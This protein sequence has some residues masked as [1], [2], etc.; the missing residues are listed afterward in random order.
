MEYYITQGRVKHPTG[1]VGFYDA[2]HAYVLSDSMWFSRLGY[3]IRRGPGHW[4][5]LLV[6]RSEETAGSAPVRSLICIGWF[7]NEPLVGV[8]LVKTRLATYKSVSA[9]VCRQHRRNSPWQL[10]YVNAGARSL[11][12]IAMKFRHHRRRHEIFSPSSVSDYDLR[13]ITLRP[14]SA[15][16]VTT[17]LTAGHISRAGCPDYDRQLTSLC[18]I[19]GYVRRYITNSWD[20]LRL[21]LAASTHLFLSRRVHDRWTEMAQDVGL[22]P[23]AYPRL[24]G[25]TAQSDSPR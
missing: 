14:T 20:V 11:V 23:A 5:G 8:S 12:T 19:P 1:E 17:G 3:R 13:H 15:V 24:A 25:K 18:R 9:S 22:K 4:V 2:Q 7:E 16:V 6:M 21:L 10:A